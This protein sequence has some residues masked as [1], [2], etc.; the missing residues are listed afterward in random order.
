MSR[1]VWIGACVLALTAATVGA[2]ER[3]DPPRLLRL[4]SGVFD[5]T[6]DAPPTAPPSAA[7]RADGG[8]WIVQAR[9]RGDPTFDAALRAAGAE[10][11]LYVPDAARLV[12][13][14]DA[15]AD[16]LTRL[17]AV[18]AVVPFRP[19]DRAPSE[20]VAAADRGTLPTEERLLL[21]A[22]KGDDAFRAAVLRDLAPFGADAPY[23]TAGSGRTLTL[24]LPS[25]AFVA[26]ARHPSVL[27]IERRGVPSPDMDVAR[28]VFGADAVEAATP[29]GFVGA[30]VAGQVLDFGPRTT[31]VD[32]AGLQ[33]FGQ[34]A[35]VPT[36]HG[37]A[38]TAIAFGDGLAQSAGRGML[39]AGSAIGGYAL[40]ADV[41]A[42]RYGYTAQLLAPPYEAVFQ[43]NSWGTTTTL[44]Y[45]AAAFALDE[46]AFDLDVAL[47]Q[48]QGNLGGPVSRA[49]AWAK[50]VVSVGG[51][52]HFG[53]A[54]TTDDAWAV[55]ASTGPAADGR[56]KPDLVGFYDQLFTASD[57]SDVAYTPF[58]SG[59]SAATPIVAG[60]GGLLSEMWSRGVFGPPPLGATVFARRPHATTTKA[61]LVNT[62][63][64]YPFAGTGG[65]L[66]RVRQG[67][68]RPDLAAALALGAAGKTF[69]VDE[70]APLAPFAQFSRAV[71]VAPG[72]PALR[73]T[74]VYADPPG[75]P[76][77]TEHR[78]NDLDL[79]LTA[80]DGTLWRGNVG[81]DVAPW[82][83]VG[84]VADEKNNVE[85][86]FIASPAAGTWVVRVVATE[87]NQDGRP[88][89][90]ALD[91]DFALVVSGATPTAPPPDVGQPN[92]ADAWLTVGA[93]ANLNFQSPGA[94]VAGPF[95]AALGPGAPLALTIGG[96]AHAPFLLA[97]G[98]LGRNNLV[99]PGLGSLDLGLLGGGNLADVVPVMNGLFPTTFLDWIATTG[100]T[101]ART[102]VF[103]N[104]GL[105][106]GVLGALQAAV[107][108]PSG[109]LLT[110]ACELS[111]Y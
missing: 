15:A 5:P 59:T 60:A 3:A 23:G 61:L 109:A 101:G 41:A 18:R 54:A 90:P 67:W 24:R 55:G 43:S 36:A 22:R 75:A 48:S 29:A 16:A 10:P 62:A 37:T 27:W 64:Q 68:G 56:V 93:S 100:P 9:R 45:G 65:D 8:L 84:G 58:F 110:A 104:P 86:V 46:I 72:E 2:Q 14:S 49:E 6:R 52:H 13:A 20:D 108:A 71:V 40:G 92:S 32:L 85:N 28:Q 107:V 88:E 79:E 81:L 94:G 87:L 31:H 25:A 35:P 105:P 17:P 50:N 26:A 82:S 80:P 4:R 66:A 30:G 111:S 91:A 47:F 96:A 95:F 1:A 74:L 12:A 106:P 53:T 76:F 78:V 69:V 99:V 63:A 42:D 73:A 34:P 57:L 38:T 70:T 44:D 89:T 11:L 39:P 33:W 51:V 7:A 103:S 102:L 21:L 97:V 77:S 19:A 98:P 83:A